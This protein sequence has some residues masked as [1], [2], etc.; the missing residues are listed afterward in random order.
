MQVEQVRQCRLE[1]E[2]YKEQVADAKQQLRQQ[3]HSLQRVQQQHQ[4][5]LEQVCQQSQR[6]LEGSALHLHQHEGAALEQV[7][8]LLHQQLF[9][10]FI[11]ITLFGFFIFFFFFCISMR[12]RPW[13][14]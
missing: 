2:A 10:L 3:A 5:L 11:I 7:G 13:N 6:A 4:Q 12:E 9:L 8:R 1:A 14:R